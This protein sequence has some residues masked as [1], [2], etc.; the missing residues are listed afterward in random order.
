MVLNR[1]EFLLMNNP[2]RA[3]IQKHFE[4]PRFRKMGGTVAGGCVLEIGCGRGVGTQ[5]IFT[6][7]GAAHVDALDLDPAMIEL[8]R[9]RLKNSAVKLWVGDATQL[10]AADGS[11]D[12]AFDFGI[13]HHIPDWRKSLAEVWRVLKPYGRFYAEEILRDFINPPLCRALFKHP[14]ESRFDHEQFIESLRQTGSD[15]F[16]RNNGSIGLAGISQKRAHEFEQEVMNMLNK[17]GANKH[18]Q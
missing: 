15:S 1:L 6:Q 18:P 3:W 8:A 12:A 16:R 13:I 9:R 11:Y 4:G 14:W 10:L 17:V 2:V 5:I 7:F